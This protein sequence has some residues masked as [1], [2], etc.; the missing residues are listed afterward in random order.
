M[1][2]KPTSN[3]D[4]FEDLSF[5][6]EKKKRVKKRMNF[7]E[8]EKKVAEENIVSKTSYIAITMAP[9]DSENEGQKN[10][11]KKS[12]LP[13]GF[14]H[15]DFCFLGEKKKRTTK[16]KKTVKE[17]GTKS[18]IVADI[19]LDSGGQEEDSDNLY[20]YDQAGLWFVLCKILSQ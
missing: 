12:D 3:T 11:D 8:F 20:S 16:S 15:D 14:F 5:I 4:N 1:E 18:E 6:G 10:G 9:Q 17:V 2:G 7:E 13:K 19:N